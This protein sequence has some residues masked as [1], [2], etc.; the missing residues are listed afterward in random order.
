MTSC[1]GNLFAQFEVRS[2]AARSSLLTY[3][4]H[5]VCCQLC[6]NVLLISLGKEINSKQCGTNVAL[7]LCF[8]RFSLGG[9]VWQGLQHG[10]E[11]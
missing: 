11:P 10:H 2:S 9:G 7:H 5:H 3:Y 6:G 1:G 4:E 8:F